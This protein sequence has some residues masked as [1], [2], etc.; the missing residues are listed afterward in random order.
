MMSNVLRISINGHDTRLIF[1]CGRQF[2]LKHNRRC[3][4][5]K[6]SKPSIG[7][8]GVREEQSSS[9]SSVALPQLAA[10]AAPHL[11]GFA[12]CSAPKVQS[13]AP[14]LLYFEILLTNAVSLIVSLADGWLPSLSVA[15]WK[16]RVHCSEQNGASICIGVATV[17]AI[18]RTYPSDK[19]TRPRIKS[20]P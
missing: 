13:E 16:R 9:S 3:H 7:D 20:R 4:R 15:D 18:Q 17:A 10:H 1:S 5:T 19:G 14:K 8:G 2:E 11:I 6:A 12:G